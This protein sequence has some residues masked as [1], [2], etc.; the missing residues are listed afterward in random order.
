MGRLVLGRPT[1]QLGKGY[2]LPGDVAQG[3]VGDVASPGH[4]LAGQ[5]VGRPGLVDLQSWL[6][7]TAAGRRD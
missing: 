2:F 1:K 3:V 7:P 5:R 4:R 6:S